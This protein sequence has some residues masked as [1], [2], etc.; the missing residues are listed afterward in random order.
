MTTPALK[1]L[2]YAEETLGVHRVHEQAHIARAELDRVLND[3]SEA[4]DKR[5]STEAQIED[6]ELELVADERG[7]HAD[8]S[9]AAMGRHLKIVFHRDGDLQ[10]LRSSLRS[11][12]GDIEGL[13]YD[14]VMH[15]TDIKIAVA[16]MQEL[17]GYL[18]YLA[19]VKST[20]NTSTASEESKA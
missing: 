9:E 1:A 10:N 11:I 7:K 3:L 17:G 5:R 4:R 14:K 15:E 16:R 2:N 20:S 13:E 6:R 18:Q 8:M 19:V 12:V